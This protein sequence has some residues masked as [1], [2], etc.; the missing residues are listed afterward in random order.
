[1]DEVRELVF[2]MSMVERNAI[3]SK[4]KAGIPA[5]LNS[6]FTDRPSREGNIEN[7]N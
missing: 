4:Y 2:S 1:M 7:Y 5:P 3:L 6:K